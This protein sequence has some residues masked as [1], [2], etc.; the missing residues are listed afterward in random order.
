V[1]VVALDV[2]PLSIAVD[3]GTVVASIGLSDASKVIGTLTNVET[4]CR[5]VV[6]AG[7]VTNTVTVTITV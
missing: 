3:G 2:V 6:G 7:A 1:V 5:D 4:V